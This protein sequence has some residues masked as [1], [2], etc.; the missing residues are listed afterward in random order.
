MQ[1]KEGGKE[2][3]R[4]RPSFGLCFDYFDLLYAAFI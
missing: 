3:K 1:K 4:E 2:G